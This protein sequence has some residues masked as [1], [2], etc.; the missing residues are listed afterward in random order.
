MDKIFNREVDRFI[1]NEEAG[2][3]FRFT[4]MGFEKWKDSQEQIET[5]R[6]IETDRQRQ[7]E[8]EIEIETERDREKDR[9][10]K[11]E[12]KREMERDRERERE[13]DRER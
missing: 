7:R 4:Y 12:R 1:S 9:E 6:A 3:K 10:R 2:M 11:R 8:R 13:R 5:G